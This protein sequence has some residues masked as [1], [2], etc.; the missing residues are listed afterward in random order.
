[1]NYAYQQPAKQ[2]S[3]YNVEHVASKAIDGTRSSDLLDLSCTH[4]M[5]GTREW[6]QVDL[7]KTVIVYAVTIT[8]RNTHWR[9]LGNF[10]I[11]VGASEYPTDNEN[12][13]C[14][15]RNGLLSGETK[16]IFCFNPIRGRYV[17]LLSWL[18]EVLTLCEVSVQARR[19][20]IRN[21][22]LSGL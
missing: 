20:S 16:P 15:G 10:K 7:G 6:W 12:P 3:N 13:T 14:A 21:E 11:S 22:S 2:S 1:M 5:K 17:T 9:R 8:N 19:I 4:T 18:D